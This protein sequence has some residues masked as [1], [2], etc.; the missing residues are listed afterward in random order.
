MVTFTRQAG[1][2]ASRG[3]RFGERRDVEPSWTRGVQYCLGLRSGVSLQLYRGATGGEN[4][5]GGSWEE[6]GCDEALGLAWPR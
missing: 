5:R 3:M 2:Q 1:A 4:H 6:G